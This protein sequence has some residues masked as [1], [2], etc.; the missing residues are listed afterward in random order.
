MLIINKRWDVLNKADP[1]LGLFWVTHDIAVLWTKICSFGN[2]VPKTATSQGISNL[3]LLSCTC[4]HFLI[5]TLLALFLLFLP[6]EMLKCAKTGKIEIL[7]SVLS[8]QHPN[9]LLN[10][11]ICQYKCQPLPPLILLHNF[12]RAPYVQFVKKSEIVHF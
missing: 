9:A 8:V 6:Q 1:Q 4:C 11:Q 2:L 7:T 10:V 3:F 5:N 12:R